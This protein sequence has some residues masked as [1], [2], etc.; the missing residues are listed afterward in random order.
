MEVTQEE[1][2][3]NGEFTVTGYAVDNVG[4]ETQETWRVTEFALDTEI[5]RILAPHEPL[6][7]RGESGILHIT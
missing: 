5:T 3:F 4:N 7:K 2:V 6:F 1:P